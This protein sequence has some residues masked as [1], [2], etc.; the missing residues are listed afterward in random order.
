MEG[1]GGSTNTPSARADDDRDEF[2]ERAA[3]T[4][5]AAAERY[6]SARWMLERERAREARDDCGS[7]FAVIPVGKCRLSRGL[8][9]WTTASASPF[10]A[11]VS[12]GY[13]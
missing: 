13:I 3:R 5:T 7:A 1:N 4:N 8:V 11:L 10:T 2:P 9:F 6:F 12:R